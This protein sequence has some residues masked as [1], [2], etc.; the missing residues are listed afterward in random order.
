MAKRITSDKTNS[1]FIKDNEIWKSYTAINPEEGGSA[2]VTELIGCN[3]DNPSAI[4]DLLLADISKARIF[5]NPLR[6]NSYLSIVAD[7][8]IDCLEDIAV[9]D[10][11]GKKQIL[12]VMQKGSK[13]FMLN[14]SGKQPG[15]YLLHFE[16]GGRQ[17]VGKVVY[18]P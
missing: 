1:F 3:V 15:T 5:P 2:L 8:E 18:I 17:I 4:D 14:F 9:Y 12:D 11:V 13:E 10:L 7:D 6:G 16:A